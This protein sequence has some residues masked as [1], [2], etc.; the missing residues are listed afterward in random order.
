MF[1]PGFNNRTS[2]SL[3]GCSGRSSTPDLEPHS[4]SHQD[5]LRV[6]GPRQAPQKNSSCSPASPPGMFRTA[7]HP[8]L[9][10]PRGM[11]RPGLTPDSEPHSPSHQDLLRFAGPRQAPQKNCSCSPPGMFR[12]AQHPNLTLLHT[13]PLSESPVLCWQHWGT[14]P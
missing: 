12:T 8:N 13:K 3:E 4:P 9:T 2:L 1:W 10:L 11:F 6:A 14:I 7:Q 5:L